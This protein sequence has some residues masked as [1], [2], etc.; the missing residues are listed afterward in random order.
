MEQTLLR[1]IINELQ[2]ILPQAPLQDMLKLYIDFAR[3]ETDKEEGIA[4]EWLDNITAFYQL[5]KTIRAHHN[6]LINP[7]SFLKKVLYVIDKKKYEDC[8]SSNKLTLY[9]VMENLGILKK[10]PPGTRLDS[11]DINKFDDPYCRAIAHAYQLRNG[12]AHTSENWAYAQMIQNVNAVMVTTLHAVWLN[13]QVISQRVSSAISNNQY[14]IDETLKKLVKEYDRKLHN[15]FSYVPLLWESSSDD[16]PK[17]ILLDELLADKQILLAGDAGCGKTTSLDQLEY[18]A[19]KKYLEGRTSVVPVKLALIDEDPSHSLPDMICRKLNIPA[20]Y[21]DSLLEKNS[22]I[23]LI[24][25]LNELTTD[26]IRKKQFVV[27][28][29]QFLSHHP[30]LGVIVTDRRYSPYLIRLKKTYHLKTMEIA[31]IVRYARTRQECTEPVLNA[32][33]HL[34]NTAAFANLEYTPLLINQLLLALSTNATPPSNH[35]ELIGIYLEALLAR[36]ATEKR[37][38]NATPNKLGLILM[39]IALETPG[40]NGYNLLH[41]MK[42]CAGIM[43]EYGT[44][45]QSDVC[46]NLAVQLGILKQSGNFVDFVLEEYRTYYLL[47]A[48]ENNL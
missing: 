2:A 14:G 19:A 33:T 46:I 26:A 17:N 8:L 32:L 13:R 48:I 16:K 30:N 28:L 27:A 4:A 25:G 36:E 24:D 40:E 10:F 12:V 9:H 15:G 29:E 35:A 47:K 41:L 18:Q 31:D 3:M 45:F 44:Q 43:A 37:D 21:C 22:M 38:L 23:L 6:Y 20:T 34:L 1:S 5:S 11:C 7:E 39:K 42:L